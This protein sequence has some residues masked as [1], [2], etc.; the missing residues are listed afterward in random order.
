MKFLSVIGSI[1]LLASLP[2]AP[3]LARAEAPAPAKSPGSCA[4][5][6][7]LSFVCGLTNVED[8][9]P[10]D[11]GRWLIGGS[12]KPGSVGLYLIDTEAKSARPVS[13][14][15]A[16]KPDP[17]YNCAAPDLKALMTH[18]LDVIPGKGEV[19]TVYAVNH[20]G[21][22]SVEIFRLNAS[23]AAA[24][25]VGCVVLPPGA[26]GNSVAALP[27]GRFAVTKFLDNNDK[28]A[29]QRILAGE[30]NGVVYLWTPGK[31][32]SE[33]KGSEL[34]GDNGILASH[35]GKWLYVNAYG[36][37]EIYRIPLA[38]EGQRASVKVDFHPDNLRW[39]PDGAILATGQFINAQ[40]LS[41]RHGWAT[42]MVD[43]RTLRVT[44]LV[45]EP[46]LAEFDDA[47][48]AVQIGR[49][50]W[51]GTFRGDRVAYRPFP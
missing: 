31:G 6:G 15:V 18:G 22:E 20:G 37:R 39:S 1:L 44:P 28:E 5:D 23:K 2:G 19:S 17:R 30:T 38:G 46:G 9:L 26:N 12:Y 51:F 8:L 13:L 43:P 25:W 45:K 41:A 16:A 24:E 34:S 36:T 21:R 32:F 27:D 42:V 14:S 47:T 10:V 33:V 4:P 48:S 40:N 49:T 11:G 7:D 50:L 35:D 3:A 29:F